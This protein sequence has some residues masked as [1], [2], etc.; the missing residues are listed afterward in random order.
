LGLKE[1]RDLRGIAFVEGWSFLIL[2]GIAM[3]LKYL[4]GWKLA[5]TI[6]GAIHGVLFIWYVVAV[7]KAAK[8]R[9]WPSGRKW[10]GL[11]ASIWP[12]GTFVFDRKLKQE[13]ATITT[14]EEARQP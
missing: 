4:A 6:T 14:P 12:F 13:E 1:L 8:I 2:L 10:E 11:I 7:L 3:P 5:V 9:N